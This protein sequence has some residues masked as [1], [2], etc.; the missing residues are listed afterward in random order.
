MLKVS[1]G[2]DKAIYEICSNLTGN[3]LKRR[4]LRC[5]GVVIVNFEQISLFFSAVSKVKFEQVN[6]SWVNQEQEQMQV[7]IPLSPVR[8]EFCNRV[9]GDRPLLYQSI[10]NKIFFFL[11]RDIMQNHITQ[12]LCL[13]AMEKP[14]TKDADDIRTEKVS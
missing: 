1:S 10:I 2:N 3:A 5:S 14:P 8:K 7:S 6:I 9:N 11:I 12:V 4:H 13:T